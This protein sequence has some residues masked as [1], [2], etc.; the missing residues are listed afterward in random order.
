VELPLLYDTTD[1]ACH[2]L[3]LKDSFGGGLTWGTSPGYVVVSLTRAE[4][5]YRGGEVEGG[6]PF[7]K[8]AIHR[9][10]GTPD[11]RL[12]GRSPYFHVLMRCFVLYFAFHKANLLLRI[13]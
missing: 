12:I 11:S 8:E 1:Y 3:T 4:M 2:T 6:S 7:Y 13:Y 10:T 5:I 9:G